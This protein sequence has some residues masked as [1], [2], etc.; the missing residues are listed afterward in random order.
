MITLPDKV[1]TV[2]V[3]EE[4]VQKIEEIAEKLNNEFGKKFSTSDILRSAIDRDLK[5]TEE[6]KDNL[7]IKLPCHDK[8]ELEEARALLESVKK[9]QS[10]FP[11][12]DSVNWALER[13]EHRVEFAE[14]LKWKAKT[15]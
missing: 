4:V 8:L 15:K 1:L 14:F 10:W 2:R 7:F 11:N 6:E 5:R 9:I 3:S 12:N 13:F